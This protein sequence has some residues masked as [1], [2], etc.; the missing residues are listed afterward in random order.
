MDEARKRVLVVDDEPGIVNIL[1]IKLKL[2]GYEVL[3]TTR[4]IEAVELARSRQP[5]IMLLDI[6]MPDI[7]GFEVLERVRIFSTVPVIVFT[8]RREMAEKALRGGA[9]AF[10]AKPFNPDQI[11]KMI[12]SVLQ[13][14]HPQA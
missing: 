1:R 8:A 13:A 7:T 12:E 11:V 3:T 6:I 2:H 10:I 4:G 9:A 5:D 14:F